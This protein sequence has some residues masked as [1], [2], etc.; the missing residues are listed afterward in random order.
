MLGY[1]SY[2]MIQHQENL[3]MQ[4]TDFFSPVKIENFTRKKKNDIFAQNIHCGYT[5]EP[6]HRGGCNEYS[7][8]MF[9]IKNKKI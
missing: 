3:P 2:D 4:Y 6:P 8:C 5:L 9:W 1:P 7:Q